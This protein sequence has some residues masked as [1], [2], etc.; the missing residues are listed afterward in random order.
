VNKRIIK[1]PLIN[2]KITQ[3]DLKR[4]VARRRLQLMALVL[5]K[6]GNAANVRLRPRLSGPASFFLLCVVL[7]RFNPLDLQK[8][9]LIRKKLVGLSDL[10][11]NQR[12]LKN[13]I[14]KNGMA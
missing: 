12:F 14:R 1:E 6:N 9:A 5:N 11:V 10:E 4:A 3:R 7:F 2:L 13:K 8:H